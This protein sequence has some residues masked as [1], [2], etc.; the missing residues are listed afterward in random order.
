MGRLWVGCAVGKMECKFQDAVYRSCSDGQQ[1]RVQ[2]LAKAK[3]QEQ[4]EQMPGSHYTAAL[5]AVR[6]KGNSSLQCPA[7]GQLKPKTRQFCDI[8]LPWSVRKR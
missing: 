3:E 5:R 7:T 2:R 4:H 6:L 1:G 8:H